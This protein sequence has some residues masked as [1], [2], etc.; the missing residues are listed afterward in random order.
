MVGHI[1]SRTA[2]RTG[3]RARIPPKARGA[4]H[5]FSYVHVTHQLYACQH[6]PAA[7]LRMPHG[8]LF[9]FLLPCCPM[10]R[11]KTKPTCNSGNREKNAARY[12]ENPA[13]RQ[14]P[15]PMPFSSQPP[16]T[17]CSVNL[18]LRE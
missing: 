17:D 11:C 15:M 5:A 3:T 6:L 16:E 7:M 1:L 13:T 14:R 10:L 4:K 9:S 18:N 8:P 12:P 2:L